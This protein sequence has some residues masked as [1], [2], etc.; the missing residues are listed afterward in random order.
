MARPEHRS[1]ADTLRVGQIDVEELR[2]A[3]SSMFPRQAQFRPGEV[4]YRTEADETALHLRSRQGRL[5]DAVSGPALTLELERTVTATIEEALADQTPPIVLRWIMFA[6]RPVNGTHRHHE[7]FQI[8]PV[9]ESAPR[10]RV[11]MAQHPFI[12]EFRVASS[13]IHEV[14]AL[15][16]SRRAREMELL[17]NLL[18]YHGVETADRE[19]GHRWVWAEEMPPSETIYR[20]LGYF[21]PDF[22]YRG[23]EFRGTDSVPPLALIDDDLYFS[24]KWHADELAL[25]A[26]FGHLLDLY[27]ALPA[28]DRRRLLRACYWL[29]TARLSWDTSKSLYLVSLVQAI[30]AMTSDVALPDDASADGPTKLFIEFMKTYGPGKPSNL[31]LNIIYE[32]RSTLTHGSRLLQYDEPAAFGL[33]EDYARDSDAASNAAT[34]CRGAIINWLASQ[35]PEKIGPLLTTGRPRSKP[36]KPGTKSGITVITGE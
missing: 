35:D 18:L 19:R 9:P 7:E 26:S 36:L 5:V 29:Q 14:Q 31:T 22:E 8:G 34:L 6:G 20:S 4:E 13:P 21:F 33:N 23:T 30:E 3:L 25:P 17:L 16:V 11:L 1:L 32:A 12:V 24:R 28:P 2:A 27:D 10:P 15:R